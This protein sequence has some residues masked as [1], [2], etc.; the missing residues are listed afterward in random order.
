M[1][2]NNVIMGTE[3]FDIASSLKKSIP[4]EISIHA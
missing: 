2:S 3:N 1:Y 4:R